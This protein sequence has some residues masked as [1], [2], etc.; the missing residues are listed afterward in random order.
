MTSFQLG[1]VLGATAGCLASAS[2]PSPAS[3]SPTSVALIAHP[4]EDQLALLH[5]T[6]CRSGAIDRPPASSRRPCSPPVEQ[7]R[8]GQR[9]FDRTF[10]SCWNP[11]ALNLAQLNCT[12]L[13]VGQ[14]CLDDLERGES[15]LDELRRPPVRL[16]VAV[17]VLL[18]ELAGIEED[19]LH[20]DQFTVGLEPVDAEPLTVEIPF[21]GSLPSAPAPSGS[22]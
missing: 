10:A 20:L 22:L 1:L 3:H 4:D 11:D 16:Y 9:G 8:A 17:G 14:L 6:A 19:A 5:R 7:R 18:G 2:A 21:V 12:F 13:A 15:G